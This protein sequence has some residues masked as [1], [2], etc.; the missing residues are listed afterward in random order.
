M[1]SD[2]MDLEITPVL[3]DP[4]LAQALQNAGAV[5]K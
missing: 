3:E 4:E 5:S 1:W 2:L